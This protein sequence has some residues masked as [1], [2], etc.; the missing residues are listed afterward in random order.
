MG[1][2]TRYFPSN[3]V[4]GIGVDHT[5]RVRPIIEAINCETA[6]L[7]TTAIINQIMRD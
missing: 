5:E 1:E 4:A 3:M 7:T 6:V 2:M